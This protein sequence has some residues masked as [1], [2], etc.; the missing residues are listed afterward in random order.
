MS[1]V[2]RHRSA[3]VSLPAIQLGIVPFHRLILVQLK[4][5]FVA[6][7]PQDVLLNPRPIHVVPLR[8]GTGSN[9]RGRGVGPC[10]GEGSPRVRSRQTRCEATQ[11]ARPPRHPRDARG[12][13]R[14]EWGQSRVGVQGLLPGTHLP[15]DPHCVDAGHI[16]EEGRQLLGLLKPIGAGKG[17]ARGEFK[18]DKKLQEGRGVLVRT[19]MRGSVS[20]V[21]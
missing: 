2:D 3:W 21:R 12:I 7:A 16:A 17:E 15:V 14:G 8:K 9:I 20:P 18:V 6:R 5:L 4:L 1:W 10:N 13:E 11:P 19:S